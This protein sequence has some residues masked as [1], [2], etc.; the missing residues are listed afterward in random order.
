MLQ[1]PRDT[2]I[3]V[4]GYLNAKIVVPEGKRRDEVITAAISDVGLEDMFAHLLL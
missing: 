2:A 4:V 1:G 3:M